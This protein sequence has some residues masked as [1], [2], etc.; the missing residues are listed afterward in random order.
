MPDR[1][2]G[3]LSNAPGKADATPC[4]PPQAT[5]KGSGRPLATMSLQELN[6]AAA[7][8]FDPMRGRIREQQH[9]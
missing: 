4:P 8:A 3:L 5:G 7:R 1:P 2:Q 9:C 6:G